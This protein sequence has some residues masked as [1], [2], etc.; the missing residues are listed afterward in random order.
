MH[1]GWTH[2]PLKQTSPEGHAVPLQDCEMQAPCTQLEPD[3][4]SIPTH[5][6]SWQV[7]PMQASSWP[8]GTLVQSLG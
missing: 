2:A 1:A 8:Q 4:H 5:S 6:E 7:L 3:A